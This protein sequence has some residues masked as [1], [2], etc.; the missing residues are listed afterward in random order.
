MYDFL[1]THMVNLL[2]LEQVLKKLLDLEIYIVF[3]KLLY[4]IERKTKK[5]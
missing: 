2:E 5:T 4:Q 1:T 3:I